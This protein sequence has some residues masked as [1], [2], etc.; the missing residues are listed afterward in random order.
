MMAF[1]FN[2]AICYIAIVYG[3]IPLCV[4]IYALFMGIG[5]IIARIYYYIEDYLTK[6]D[7]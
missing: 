2:C 6:G 1:L 5:G 3:L 7:K 4:L